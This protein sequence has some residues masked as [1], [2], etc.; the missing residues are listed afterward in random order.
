VD[1]RAEAQ[2]P[3]RPVPEPSSR[4]RGDEGEEKIWERWS[5]AMEERRW[6]RRKADPQVL[7]PRLS[8]VREGSWREM[9]RGEVDGEVEGMV[10]VRDMDGMPMVL[11]ALATPYIEMILLLSLHVAKIKLEYEEVQKEIMVYQFS[12]SFRS[13]SS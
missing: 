5:E 11:S 1:Q 4:M 6:E 12:H 10:K 7:K 13:A 9:E 2:R 8:P 3:A